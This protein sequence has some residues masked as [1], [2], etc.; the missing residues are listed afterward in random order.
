MSDRDAVMQAARAVGLVV[1]PCNNADFIAV[2]AAKVP[3]GTQEKMRMTADGAVFTVSDGYYWQ[4]G[5]VSDIE[6]YVKTL[7]GESK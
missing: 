5:S 6:T 3:P 4:V 7:Q 2:R 1:E